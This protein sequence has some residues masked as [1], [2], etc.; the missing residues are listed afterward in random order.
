[1]EK[2]TVAERAAYYASFFEVKERDNGEQF[3]CLKN[4]APEELTEAVRQAHGDKFPDDFIY[5]TFAH[6]LDAV[7]QYDNL[8]SDTE[9]EIA[10]SLVDVYTHDLTAWLHSRNDRVGY[11]TE[12]LEQPGDFSGGFDLLAT[13]QY[14]EIQEVCAAVWSLLESD[15][16]DRHD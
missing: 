15:N 14:L 12:V 3:Y 2:K 1:M 11:L 5:R 9:Q 6:A 7:D 8:D 13:A 16:T 10:D 4:D